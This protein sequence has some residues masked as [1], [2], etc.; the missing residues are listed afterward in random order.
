MEFECDSEFCINKIT[1]HIREN[2]IVCCMKCGLQVDTTNNFYIPENNFDFSSHYRKSKFIYTKLRYFKDK[3]IQLQGKET[4]FILTDDIINKIKHE[5]YNYDHITI[6]NLKVFFRKHKLNKLS[7]HLNFIYNAL[8]N[9]KNLELDYEDEIYL[10]FI[11]KK[12]EQFIIQKN[13]YKKFSMNFHH[14][15]YRFLKHMNIKDIDKF[16]NRFYFVNSIS[17][18]HIE[19]DLDEFFFQYIKQQH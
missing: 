18:I 13:D 19:Q 11:F 17:K 7:H 8:T 4:N 9:N 16:K 14:I 1:P 15:L 10:I 3:I 6:E 2:G 5:Y 12:Y